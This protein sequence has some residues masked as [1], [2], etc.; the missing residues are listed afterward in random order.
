MDNQQKTVWITGASSGIGRS[1]ALA[2]AKKGYRLILTARRKERLEKLSETVKEI[3]GSQS[4]ILAADLSLEGECYRICRK[5]K[6]E[7]LDIFINNAGFGVCGEFGRTSLERE[8]SMVDVNIRAMHILFK[9]AVRKMKNKGGGTIL[10]VGSSAGL[11]P[12]GPYMGAYYASKAYVVSLTRAV[13]QELREKK[14][15]V[16]VYVLCPGPVDTEF[17][18]SVGVKFALKGI[19]PECCVEKALA[20]MEGKNPVIVPTRLL[21]LGIRFQ[22]MLPKPLLLWIIARQQK[23][24]LYS[25]DIP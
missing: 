17:N 15:P 18:E 8:L 7:R 2:Y 11:F 23:K 16:K 21:R 13:A 3:S 6:E 9:Y 4:R 1:F 10:N 20:G 5:L 22:W 25:A 19:T 12:G 14:S 24:K